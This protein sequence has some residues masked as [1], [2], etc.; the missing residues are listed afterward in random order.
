MVNS[1][2]KDGY[3]DIFTT[4]GY[5]ADYSVSLKAYHDIR[6]FVNDGKNKFEEKVF[7]PVYGIQKAI[8]ADFDK[9]GDIDF[10]SIAFFPD[11]EKNPKE[12]FI[13]W[14]N[15]GHTNYNRFTFAASVSGRW[16]T[17]D[18]GDMDGDGDKDIIPGSTV[19]SFGE[20]PQQLKNEWSKRPVS[21]VILK[22]TLVD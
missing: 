9:D 22:Y 19:F 10:V 7:L 2:V 16:L 13:Y 6:I 1:A 15:S 5:K 21:V 14:E 18:A 8:P 3:M 11:Y 17:M 20:V 12:S 4:N